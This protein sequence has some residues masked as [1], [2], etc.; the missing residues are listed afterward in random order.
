MDAAYEITAQQRKLWAVQ[1]DLIEK[2]KQICKKHGIQYSATGGT[3]L[4]AARHKGFIP[5]DDDV[6][7]R[8]LWPDYQKLLEVAPQECEYPYFFQSYFTDPEGEACLSKLRRSDTTG[9][10]QWEH[11][12]VGEGYNRG[13][14]I[15]I[16]PMFYVPDDPEVRKIQREKVMFL[17]K[18]IRGHNALNQMKQGLPVHEE[19]QA[20]IPVYEQVKSSMT[21]TEIKTEYL[22]A[23]ALVDTPQREV[24]ATA[25]RIYLPTLMWNSEWYRSYIDLPFE[26]TTISCPIDYEKVLEKQ[27]GDWR[28]P[29]MNG[30]M[31]EMFVVDTETPYTEY[32]RR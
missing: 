14:F 9:F 24:G 30:A 27:Y 10:T 4:G 31:H 15:D 6:D 32:V 22:H 2:L 11:D 1:L 8:L 25:S 21:I 29:V 28:T 20:C 13:I 7:V 18:C 12:N 17:W 26:N 3:L 19:Y 16:F 23:C 5:W